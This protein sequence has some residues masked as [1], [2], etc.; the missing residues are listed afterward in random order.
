[1]RKALLH[2]QANHFYLYELG[3]VAVLFWGRLAVTLLQLLAAP[4]SIL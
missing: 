4:Q 1:M 3:I 2:R